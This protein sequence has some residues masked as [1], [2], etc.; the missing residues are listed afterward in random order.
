MIKL[1]ALKALFASLLLASAIVQ[2][3]EETDNQ[4]ASKSISIPSNAT[5]LIRTI[6]ELDSYYE[7][8]AYAKALHD[9]EQHNDAA[10]AYGR[11]VTLAQDDK[12]RGS[13]LYKQAQMY[14]YGD[15]L[16]RSMALYLDSAELG[17]KTGNV[18]LQIEAL[19][20][21]AGIMTELGQ[22]TQA[23]NELAKAIS[24][25]RTLYEQNPSD[26]VRQRLLRLH[27]NKATVQYQ[28]QD[29]E[30]LRKTL[31]KAA[32]YSNPN[33]PPFMHGYLGQL[34]GQ[35]ARL[36]GD[37]TRAKQRLE[38]AYANIEQAPIALFRVNLLY[39]LVLTHSALQNSES[40]MRYANEMLEQ[41]KSMENPLDFIM[42][43][44]LEAQA[45][46]MMSNQ[47]YDKAAQS[48]LSAYTMLKAEQQRRMSSELI[49]LN[50]IYDGEIR[51][52]ELEILRQD[53]QNK[54]LVINQQRYAVTLSF[55]VLLALAG[56]A[57]FKFRQNAEREQFKQAL[58]KEKATRE[59]RL[60]MSRELHDN[61][62]QG[63][64]AMSLHSQRALNWA[65]KDEGKLHT[66]LQH[67]V[68]LADKTAVEG[69]NAIEQYRYD[70]EPISVD[71][72]LTTLKHQISDDRIDFNVPKRSSGA[73]KT[74]FSSEICAIL[75]E[76][77]RN[78]VKHA[79]A[80]HIIVSVEYTQQKWTF[81]VEDDGNGFSIDESK[82]GHFGLLGMQERADSIDAKMTTN[83]SSKGTQIS[84]VLA[85]S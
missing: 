56:F 20:G 7:A 28:N 12:Q 3:C 36:A 53:T 54:D 45:R 48:F 11:A 52:K 10:S 51:K 4:G 44:A 63:V 72:L 80:K 18:S 47:D 9:N 38:K 39:E 76:A 82:P 61:L 23:A 25:A 46:A 8:C 70:A 67:L 15:L 81:S 59:E 31:T 5:E 13:A 57:I 2:A 66:S 79:H 32:D 41:A 34:E 43:K 62:L 27:Y 22:R 68:E 42:P 1:I 37:L 60:R 64:M 77:M 16:T 50:D 85:V 74:V 49:W 14:F 73:W 40:A 71:Y 30:A 75:L 65:E 35:Y 24:L 29:V 58:T 78:A 84:I 6:Q 26:N 19:S 83:T 55:V 21:R 33:D 17:R 69:R